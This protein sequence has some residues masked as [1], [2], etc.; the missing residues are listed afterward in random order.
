M[1]EVVALKLKTAHPIEQV[2]EVR[3]QHNGPH[4]GTW[5]FK[6]AFG[7]FHGPYF[8]EEEAKTSLA[9]I[10]RIAPFA[11]GYGAWWWTDAGGVTHG[12]YSNLRDADASIVE[13]LNKDPQ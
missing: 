4:R 7:S 11:D 9:Q 3:D 8:T 13:T 2:F 5:W 1:G 10:I 12:P 6:D